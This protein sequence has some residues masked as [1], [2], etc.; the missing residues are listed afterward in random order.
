MISQQNVFIRYYDYVVIGLM[1][2]NCGDFYDYMQ[3]EIDYCSKK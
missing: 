2:T 1:L 3:E